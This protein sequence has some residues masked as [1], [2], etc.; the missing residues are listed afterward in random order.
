[1]K[2]TYYC[3]DCKTEIQPLEPDS[4]TPKCPRGSTHRVTKREDGAV[5]SSEPLSRPPGFGAEPR[6]SKGSCTRGWGWQWVKR[7]AN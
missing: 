1:M 7:W 3:E 4:L 6:R 2:T 5:V